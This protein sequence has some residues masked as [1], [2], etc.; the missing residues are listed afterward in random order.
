MEQLITIRG[1]GDKLAVEANATDTRYFSLS[2]SITADE[3]YDL[4]HFE[5]GSTYNISRGER[6]EIAEGSFEGFC[7][8]IEEI[9]RRINALSNRS[10]AAPNES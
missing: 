6:G 10:E 8:L 1:E 2:N 4:F 5:V 9:A 7:E 3:I